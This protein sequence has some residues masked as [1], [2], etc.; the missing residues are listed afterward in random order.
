MV[1]NFS[2]CL[3]MFGKIPHAVSMSLHSEAEV[4][5]LS[6]LNAWDH[7]YGVCHRCPALPV[8]KPVLPSCL[9]EGVEPG[10]G[11]IGALQQ[12]AG[13]ELGPGRGVRPQRGLGPDHQAVHPLA[14]ERAGRGNAN[15]GKR[16]TLSVTLHYIT[17]HYM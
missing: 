15:A 13:P 12:R 6:T 7:C 10:R 3:I 11:D 9:P 5:S 4:L 16:S 1:V 17:L 14:K 2:P 8:K